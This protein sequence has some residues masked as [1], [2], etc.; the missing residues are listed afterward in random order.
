MLLVAQ[1]GKKDGTD[2]ERRKSWEMEITSGSGRKEAAE[3]V[4]ESG[5]SG[6]IVVLRKGSVMQYKGKNPKTLYP[7]RT[8]TINC[9]RKS[10]YSNCIQ[11]APL[12]WGH[13][14]THIQI[15]HFGCIY[16]CVCATVL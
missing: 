1:K 5:R 4:E 13:V 16:Y 9:M 15:F 7:C 14:R 12:F 8:C 3:V 2:S 11:Y 10:A 6:H